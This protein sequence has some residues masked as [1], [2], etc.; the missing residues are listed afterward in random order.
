MN[1]KWHYEKLCRSRKYKPTIDKDG[2][3][4]THHILPKS[5]GGTEDDEN[6]VR[7]TA[8][9]HFIAH[10][11]LWKMTQDDTFSNWKMARA[12]SYNRFGQHGRKKCIN[13]WRYEIAKKAYSISRSEYL[14]ENQFG[15]KNHAAI[16]DNV[17]IIDPTGK[18]QYSEYLIETLKH[19][20]C[21]TWRVKLFRYYKDTG[22]NFKRWYIFSTQEKAQTFVNTNVELFTVP[23]AFETTLE[24]II[25]CVHPDETI[26]WF[27]NLDEIIAHFNKYELNKQR[28][29]EVLKGLRSH[30]RNFKFFIK[31]EG[32]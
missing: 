14:R 21:S 6:L 32:N 16:R 13:S 8:R 9:E 31:K 2:Y 24:K 30:H 17:W 12:L 1:Y 18:I 10:L 15:R 29:T 20:N 4:E 7:L 26:S 25:K 3:Y 28:I 27:N 11:L 19:I 22:K 23:V 5:L